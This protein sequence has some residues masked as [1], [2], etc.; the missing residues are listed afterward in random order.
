MYRLACEEF[1][2]FKDVYS[3]SMPTMT[4]LCDRE[5]LLE[6]ENVLS[7]GSTS[8]AIMHY[9]INDQAYPSRAEFSSK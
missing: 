8:E 7:D 3:H 1:W 6:S 2:E 9:F 5:I 4:S